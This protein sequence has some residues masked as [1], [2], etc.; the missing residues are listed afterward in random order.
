MTAAYCRMPFPSCWCV[1][2]L[3]AGLATEIEEEYRRHVVTAYPALADDAVWEAGMRRAVAAWTVDVTW[4]L[5]PRAANSESMYAIRADA[6][7]SRQV[8]RHRWE[9]AA[10]LTEFPA[11]AEAMRRL[12]QSI[13]AEWDEPQLPEYPAFRTVQLPHQADPGEKLG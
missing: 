9:T 10:A 13:T 6:P 11:L 5:L 12:L 3:P 7:T 2:R 4:W 8:L 1:F